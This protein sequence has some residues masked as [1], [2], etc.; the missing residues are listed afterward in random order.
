MKKNL[1]RD[2]GRGGLWLGGASTARYRA[3]PLPRAMHTLGVEFDYFG[4]KEVLVCVFLSAAIRD[5]AGNNTFIVVK[6]R[7]LGSVM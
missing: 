5:I 4:V 6:S 1:G 3:L 7:S 2:K